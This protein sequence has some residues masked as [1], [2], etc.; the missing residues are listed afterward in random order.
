MDSLSGRLA[1]FI[2]G[3]KYKSLAPEVIRKA[4]HCL[5]DTLGAALAG[6][7]TPEALVAKRLAQRLSQRR[8]RPFLPPEEKWESWKQPWPMGSCPMPWNWMMATAM[9]RGTPEWR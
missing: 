2:A 1:T 9:L 6:S 3:L 5:M 8:R 7:K 4:K